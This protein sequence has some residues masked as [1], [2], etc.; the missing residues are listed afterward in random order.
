MAEDKKPQAQTEVRETTEKQ[1]FDK[2]GKLHS[3]FQYRYVTRRA[4]DGNAETVRIVEK[5]G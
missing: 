3:G 5:R 4:A 1:A 2:N